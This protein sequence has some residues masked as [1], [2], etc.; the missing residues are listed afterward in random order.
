MN[1]VLFSKYLNNNNIMLFDYQKRKLYYQL[2][3]NNSI[4]KFIKCNNKK[5]IINKSYINDCNFS[6]IDNN[7][8]SI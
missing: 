1:F 8:K 2:K 3:N 4:N 5:I 7:Y 6:Y